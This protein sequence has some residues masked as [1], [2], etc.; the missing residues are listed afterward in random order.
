MTAAKLRVAS[1]ADVPAL[2]DMMEDFNRIEA[3]AWDRVAAEPPLR[4]LLGAPQLGRIALVEHLLHRRIGT[5]GAKETLQ[6]VQ[7]A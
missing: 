2:L 6:V 4:L 5:H 1:A 7:A 3:I